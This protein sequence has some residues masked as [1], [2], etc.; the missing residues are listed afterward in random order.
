MLKPLYPLGLIQ[1]RDV[2]KIIRIYFAIKVGKS[3]ILW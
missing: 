1:N 3:V 2:D